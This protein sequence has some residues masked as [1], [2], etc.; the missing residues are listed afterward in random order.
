MARDNI[1]SRVGN[2]TVIR[3]PIT[4]PE[5]DGLSPPN[6]TPPAGVE[7]PRDGILTQLRHA[8]L[9]GRPITVPATAGLF[10]RKLR[11]RRVAHWAWLAVVGWAAAIF[12]MVNFWLP[13][14]LSASLNIYLV[15]PLLWSSLAL[16]AFL[17]WRYSLRDRPT[18]SK[19]LVLMAILTGAFQ[20]A[21]FVMAGLFFG[22]GYSPYGHRPLVLLG[23]LVYVG[24]MLVGMEM[25]R[26]YLVTL[27]S[28]RSPILAL[29]LVSFLFSLMCIPVAQFGLLGSV[30]TAFRVS[31][32]T[33][34]PTLSENLL[35]SFLALVGGP[36]ASIAYRATL[37]AFEWLSPILP[38]L[39]WTITAF[40]GT[41]APALG[42]LVIRTLYLP[43]AVAEEEKQSSEGASPIAWMMV[44]VVGVG[45]LWFNT[46]L[47]GVRP[48]LI[49]GA[50][51]QPALVVGD[52]AI[53]RDVSPDD[54]EVG[55]IIRYQ[56]GDIFILHRVVEVEESGPN[57]I[58]R[59]DANNVNDDPVLPTQL[60]GKLVL[61]VPKIGWIPIGI[62][63]FINRLL[64]VI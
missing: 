63:L 64:G 59:G 12:I 36:V 40:F 24:S 8:T 31:G 41:L 49:S 27:F 44:A 18:L 25:S 58:T 7:Q 52:I 32:E 10:A 62:R 22:F 30:P 16:L 23:N 3:R 17:A 37:Q 19:P 2:E 13:R 46:G 9:D 38:N 54:V 4:I 14:A 42:L 60:A 34:L 28:R 50:S 20:V 6:L 61:V 15:Q 53:T 48:T 51:M 45:L 1:L 21:L 26:A 33:F 43:E 5:T 57:F 55:D 47:F 11:E 39:E 56:K 35:A 29:A